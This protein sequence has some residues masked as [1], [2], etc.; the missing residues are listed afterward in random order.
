ME[1]DVITKTG[2]IKGISTG[3]MVFTERFI[4]Y[5]TLLT[6]VLLGN[7]LT[8]D[9]VFSLAQLFNIVQHY[10]AFMF[11]NALATYSEARVSIRRIEQIL[12]LE[13]KEML[14]P[15]WKMVVVFN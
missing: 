14:K 4:L 10:V 9:V 6:Y 15:I 8:G 3:M 1:I 13:E 11:P 5:L 7:T 2:Y 12:L